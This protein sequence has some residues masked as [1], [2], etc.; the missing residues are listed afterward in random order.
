M[1]EIDRSQ[2]SKRRMEVRFLRLLLILGLISI[3]VSVVMQVNALNFKPVAKLPVGM[4]SIGIAMELVQSKQDVLDLTADPENRKTLRTQQQLDRFPFI[5]SYFFFFATLGAYG[6]VVLDRLRWTGYA[7]IILV[8]MAALFDYFEDSG[9]IYALDHLDDPHPEHIWIWGYLKWGLIYAMLIGTLPL[10]WRRWKSASLRIL[11]LPFGLY[12]VFS[13][14][15]GVVACFLRHGGRIESAAS[16]LAAPIL[17][18]VLFAALFQYGVV[19]GLTAIALFLKRYRVTRWIV[20]WPAW[21][22]GKDH[23][24]AV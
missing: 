17:F 24:S 20:L 6:I 21:K 13:G 19:R 23:P 4:T 9:I 1:P 16:G 11:G 3:L 5:P 10:F 22:A 12:A 18:F 2:K 7:I 8:A 14:A 15:A